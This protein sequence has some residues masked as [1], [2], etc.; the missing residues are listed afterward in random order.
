MLTKTQIDRLEYD[1]AGPKMQIEYDGAEIPGFGVRVHQS[2]RKTFVLTYR[3]RG[4]PAPKRIVL[5]TFGPMTLDEARR[6]AR[7]TLLEAKTGED[8]LEARRKQRHGDT[9]RD[10]AKLYLDRHAKAHKKT[11][12]ED[13]RRINKHIL[14]ALGARRVEDVSR[15]DVAR[16]H[17]RIGQSAPIEA[18]RVVKLF[19][20]MLNKAEEFGM[21]EEGSP[22][23][24]ARVKKFRE[25][26]RDRWVTPAELP[27][28]VQ[29]IEAEP[30]PHVRAAVKLYL[31]T[32][33]RRSE[34][35]GLRWRD[36][37]VDRR[38][39]RLGETK[40]G[41]P[42][43]LP[44]STEALDVLRDLPRQ[45][46]TAYVFPGE[47]PGKPLVNIN[48]PWRRIRARFWLAQNPDRAAEL[49]ARAERDVQRRSKHA[50]KTPAAVEHRLI[51][52]AQRAAKGEEDVRLHDL[53]RTVGSWLATS[54]ASLPL[55]GKVLNHSSAS[56]TQ[57][58][59]RL[60]EDAT[61][62]ALEA[63]GA[64]IGPLLNAG[65]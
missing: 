31:L 5:G 19:A 27:A 11:W 17:N 30:S 51:A 35:L 8:P 12:K 64:A 65:G 9:V 48:K 56:T 40:A 46:G 3:T 24:A 36:V 22:N 58:Y 16:L 26:S 10:L 7:A 15:S 50:E 47:V 21:L 14:P 33:L 45:L 32:G 25:T 61:R 23:P 60:A 54:G 39:I 4:R 28:L 1:P 53:R 62:A 63:H 2:G 13:E 34:L 52:L 43:I 38:E 59:A 57:I 29:A 6:I 55:I 20:V 41:R 49:T 44:L 42:H 18:N 37:N